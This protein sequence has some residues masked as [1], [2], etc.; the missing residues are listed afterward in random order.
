LAG[1][2][3]TNAPRQGGN[4]RFRQYVRPNPAAVRPLA[5]GWRKRAER[6]LVEQAR[7]LPDNRTSD[8]MTEIAR[9]DKRIASSVGMSGMNATGATHSHVLLELVSR[10]HQQRRE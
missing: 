5:Y 2:R 1:R 4:A 7:Q 10:I 9:K 8:Q 3:V 6:F